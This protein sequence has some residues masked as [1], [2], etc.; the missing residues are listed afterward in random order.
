MRRMLPLIVVLIG[1]LACSENALAVRA[2]GH[3]APTKKLEKAFKV[4][5]SKRVAS[6]NG[7]Y[8]PERQAA[9]VIR[10]KTNLRTSVTGRLGSAGGAGVVN[11]IRRGTSCNRLLLALRD[12]RKLYILDSNRGP[13]YVQGHANLEGAESL[14]G[15]RGPLRALTLA[16]KSFRM[17]KFDQIERLEVFCP[18]GKFPLGGGMISTPPLSTD[19]EGVY[20]HS[21][22]RLGVQRGFHITAFVLDPTPGDTTPRRT[23][24]QVIC[25]R[26]LVPTAA[27]HKTVF[28]PRGE[29]RTT[30]ARCPR[31]T[32]LFSG[33]YQRTNFTTPFITPGGNYIT[34]SRA[35]GTR[36]WQVSA[37]SVGHDGGEL[38]SI[39]YCAKDPSLPLTEV[40]ASTPL[41]GG[42]SA[43]AT[44]PQCPPGTR[45]TTGGF[46]FEGSENAF[47]ADGYFNPDDGT[48][49]ATGYGYFGPA[50]TLTA[51]GYCLR[52]A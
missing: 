25:G 20:P 14:R 38:T 40:S 33:G 26:G 6:R 2:G 10:R 4:V 52:A 7:C 37:T 3:N 47:L 30:I 1:L 12:G 39:A 42:L 8:P 23:T 11:V 24:V 5:A 45:L 21:Y 13:V 50:P 36:A 44:T 29:T 22:E 16:T 35:I 27:P 31:G 46:S 17:S 41:E 32:N 49:S 51:Y 15:G 9:G 48:W 19:G 28:V 43:T 34:E 18:K